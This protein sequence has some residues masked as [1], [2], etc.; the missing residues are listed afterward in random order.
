MTDT[1]IADAL[2][3]PQDEGLAAGIADGH[4]NYPSAGYF[5]GLAEAV[6]TDAFVQHGLGFT[7][8]DGAAD[9]VDVA[10]GRAF[11][12][13]SS[14]DVQTG[15]GGSTAPSYDA[16]L[17]NPIFLMLDLPTGAADLAVS[18]GTA[19]PVW[20]A[21]AA[22]GAVSNIEVEDIYLR[23]GS[24]ETA[25]PH[26]SV[27]LGETNPDSPGA[28]TLANRG[29][30]FDEATI[31]DVLTDAAG[32]DHTGE[33]ADAVDVS[34][35]Q[36]SSDVDHDSTQGGTDADAHHAKTTSGDID[37]NATTNRTHSG[38]DISPASVS[39][40]N[41]QLTESGTVNVGTVPGNSSVET[42]VSFSQTF[43]SAPIVIATPGDSG[44]MFNN[45]TAT[46]K[47]V[48]TSGFD[49]AVHNFNSSSTGPDHCGW[50]ALVQ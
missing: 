12:R 3:F 22:D 9:E 2:Q 32:V 5:G 16:T 27:K 39:T 24:G 47:N 13:V 37:H 15:L 8:H 31:V 1:V 36:S 38:D 46:V 30:T 42:A 11:V 18:S 4:E 49:L 19:N 10:A 20:L 43:S 28:D 35:I 14:V 50:V 26:P 25:P 7:N 6:G 29:P 48:S 41:I 45:V 17:S 34:S 40:D 23:H 44:G 33:L 21:F